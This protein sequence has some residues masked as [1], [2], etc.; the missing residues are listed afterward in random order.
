VRDEDRKSSIEDL[1]DRA[2]AAV[3]RGDREAALTL[4]GRVLEVDQ[5]NAEAEDLLAVPSDG[6]EIRRL[7]MLFADLVDSTV[8]SSRVEPETYRLLV[9]RYRQ[10][11][12]AVVDRYE[13]HIGSTKGDGLLA[14][15][16]H[17]I[18]HEDDVQRAV[19]AG[20]AIVRDVDRLDE[21]SRRRFGIEIAVRVGVHR[22]LVY[23]D[24]NQDD[25]YGLGANLTARV[26]GLAKPQTVVVSAAVE[27]L[28]RGSFE[29]EACEPA[30]VKGV[31]E[32]IAHHRVLGERVE[33]AKGR[34]RPLVGRDLEVGRLE[35]VWSQAQAATLTTPGVV[36]WGEPGIGKSRLAA[37]AEEMV[38][39]SGGVV[40]EL[41]GSA[42][43]T[44]TGLRPVRGL[45]ER[46]CGINR[47]TAQPERLRLLEADVAALGLDPALVAL[48]APVAG[49]APEAGYEQVAVEGAKLFGLIADAVADYLRACLGGQPAMLLVED[50]HWFDPD[51]LE[52]LE[53]LLGTADGRLLVVIT[54]RPGAWLPDDW[55]VDLVKLTALNDEAADALIG[56]LNPALTLDERAAVRARCDGVPFYIEQVVSGLDGPAVPEA[57][58]EP[59]FARLRAS[60]NAVPVVQAAGIIGR[61]VDRGLLGTVC[62]MSE[63]DVDDVIVELEKALVFEQWGV[64]GWRFRHEL[65]RE[66]AVELA[67]P[68]VRR[69]L[70]AK[71]AD[72]L[73]GAEGNPDWGLVAGHYARADRFDSA[74]LASQQATTDARRRGA[75]N[76]ARGYLNQAVEQVS[77]A[78][79]GQDR[80]RRETSIRLER[81]W[82]VAS[83]DGGLSAAAAVDFDRCLELT[84]TY[85]HAQ[86]VEGVLT[87][88]E[89]VESYIMRADPRR[90]L[91]LLTAI[92]ASFGETRP[93]NLMIDTWLGTV[94]W[95]SGDFDAAARQLEEAAGGFTATDLLAVGVAPRLEERFN[96]TAV[97]AYTQLVLA[98]LVRGELTAAEA[99]LENAERLT[100]G[101]KFPEEQFSLAFVLFVEIWL[102]LE[103]GDLDRA[104]M[105]AADVTAMGERHGLKIIRLFGET[106]QAAV[107]AIGTLSDSNADS[108]SLAERI[109]TMTDRVQTLRTVE[110][111]EFVTYFNSVIARLLIA[112]GQL[113][114]ARAGLDA[115]QRIA[116]DTDM[117]FYNA[118]LLRLRARTHAGRDARAADLATA[119]DL[120]RRQGGK[121]FE[122]RAAID[123]VE[124]RGDA[125]IPA[126]AEVVGRFLVDEHWPE[127]S[128]AQSLLQ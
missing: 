79:P 41:T 38:E 81:G 34:N 91:Q 103:A 15:F 112:D 19:L 56:T 27:P 126:L 20:L 29:L 128:V 28:I 6:G 109:A 76:E 71:V 101:F 17:P 113:A 70:H 60:A 73:V 125:A 69:R 11:V 96:L 59:L 30:S 115:A 86:D 105:V 36:Y 102:R 32:L 50:A 64:D 55:P 8:L 57:L 61:H 14:V 46:R 43:H 42:F 10:Q 39:R 54:G 95:F 122:L 66:V 88:L 118:E 104:S 24:T 1:L 67:P 127:L 90:V 31:E 114:Q 107:D 23:L 26:S 77:R 121:L 63:A 37:L 110:V 106:W 80:D 58:Y 72:A 83:A 116:D 4:A 53:A 21:Q 117:R 22:G 47:L 40:V 98:H 111:N 49:I 5:S 93:F 45:L 108:S 12:L 25:V 92:G 87:L 120:A 62:T 44:G 2:A 84:G 65:L 97:S 75:L 68:T 78:A 74:A 85:L 13:G 52:I 35:K 99:A 119:R 51:T 18:A 94:A 123:D 100:H 16:G 89:V 3:S 33:R 9:G 82:L 48:L 7:T 124:L